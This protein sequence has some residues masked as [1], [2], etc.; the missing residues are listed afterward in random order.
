[1][2]TIC[3]AHIDMIQALRMDGFLQNNHV[4]S[5]WF[6]E[7]YPT[8]TLYNYKEKDRIIVARNGDEEND[9]D[10]NVDDNIDKINTMESIYKKNAKRKQRHCMNNNLFTFRFNN[11]KLAENDIIRYL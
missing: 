7:K 3:N 1:M 8:C 9:V 2:Y 11:F 4:L 6:H 10:D 5:Q